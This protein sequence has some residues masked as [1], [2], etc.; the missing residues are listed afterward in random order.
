MEMWLVVDVQ[1]REEEKL[2]FLGWG[3]SFILL[4]E[5]GA[6]ADHMG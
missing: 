3:E 1:E 4:D 5:E 2:V 6:M